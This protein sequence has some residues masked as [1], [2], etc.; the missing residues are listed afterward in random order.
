MKKSDKGF[1]IIELLIVIAI[2]GILSATVAPKLLKELRKGKVAKIQHN[3]GVIR[4]KLSLDDSLSDEFPNLAGEEDEDNTDLLISYSIEPTLVFTNSDGITYP[5]TDQIVDTRD[6]TGGWLYDRT[7]GDIYANLPN[8]AYTYDEEYEVWNDEEE[9]ESDD[10]E[11]IVEDDSGTDWDNVSFSKT[12]SNDVY[13]GCGGGYYQQPWGSGE[14]VM[15]ID[16]GVGYLN[17]SDAELNG[18]YQVYIDGEL[19]ESDTVTTSNDGRGINNISSHT[20]SV[21][22]DAESLEIAF[23]YVDADGEV[24]VIYNTTELTKL[25]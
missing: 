3:L 12:E 8:G 1:T 13:T 18:N 15:S 19:I 23:E 9:T 6:N 11:E 14:Y 10:D 2:I 22:D 17:I 25:N 16:P 5:E 24:K 4:S 7:E 20:I 21:P